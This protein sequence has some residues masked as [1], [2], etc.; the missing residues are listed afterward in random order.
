MASRHAGRQLSGSCVSSQAATA[1]LSGPH[2]PWSCACCLVERRVHRHLDAQQQRNSWSRAADAG[3]C[4]G[5]PRRD[6]CLPAL[7]SSAPGGCAFLLTLRH[8]D[9][10]L[11]KDR[12]CLTPVSLLCCLSAVI[13]GP[14][15]A[16]GLPCATAGYSSKFVAVYGYS[17]ALPVAKRLR[18]GLAGWMQVLSQDPAGCQA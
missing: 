2:Q 18:L 3:H 6:A 14:T 15:A 1:V 10:L 11:P 17:G 8:R 5:Q 9:L 4:S 7:T 13:R 16:G 12:C